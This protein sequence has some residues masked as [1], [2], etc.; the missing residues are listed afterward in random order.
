MGGCVERQAGRS[1]FKF[2]IRVNYAKKA[3]CKQHHKSDIAE[4]N[5]TPLPF[6]R[7]L[8]RVPSERLVAKPLVVVVTVN[9]HPVRALVDSGSLGDLISTAVADQLALQR[10]ELAEPITLQLAVQGSRSKINH[11]EC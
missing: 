5:N 7:R 6:R 3:I 1:K 4:P 8:R 11:S 10:E 9:G 2:P